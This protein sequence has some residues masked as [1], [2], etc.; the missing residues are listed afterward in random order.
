[1]Q[2][3]RSVDD[4]A[5]RSGEPATSPSTGSSALFGRTQ[6]LRTILQLVDD[7][8]VR[9]V[10]LTGPGGVGKTRLAGEVAAMRPGTIVV[11]LA[12]V[13][14]ES[15]VLPAIAAA[16]GLQTAGNTPLFDLVVADLA[17]RRALLL[18]DNLEHLPEIGALV[19]DLLE[20]CPAVRI[21]ATSRRRL[22]LSAEHEVPVPPLTVPDADR[23][24]AAADLHALGAVRL[25][26]QRSR[27]A[28]PAFTLTDSNASA[29]AAICR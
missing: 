20:A 14:N 22:H 17:D 19:Y 25:F 28:N 23:S 29:V 3:P 9:L 10:T 11:S 6:T 26:V 8:S 7:T 2:E 18:L 24:Y 4:S 21:L 13:A 12:P 27:A 16:T 5:Y 1:M 15:F